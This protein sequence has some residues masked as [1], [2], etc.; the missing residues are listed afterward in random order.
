MFFRKRKNSSR[1]RLHLTL[2]GW[3][4]FGACFLVGVVAVNSGM[5]L[6]IVLLG[7]LL[8]SIHI[9]AVLSRR[10]ISG[11]AVR[12][13]APARCRQ[14]ESVG[15]GYRLTSLRGAGSCL[16]LHV[17]ES[18]TEGLHVPPAACGHLAARGGFLLRSEVL[19]LHRGRMELRGVRL[20]T[21]FPF[22]LLWARRMF[23]QP[24]SLVVWPARGTLAR[25]LLG[26][27][28]AHSSSINPSS[29]SGGADEFVGL[30][31]YR[32]GDSIRWIHLRRSAGRHMPVV[33]EMSKP[34]P[35]TL[36]VILDTLLDASTG[37][38]WAARE[39]AIRLA[40]TLIEDG[41]AAG[42]RV[43][44]AWAQ[45][46]D[47]RV[48]PPAERPGQLNVL[49]D[50]LAEVDENRARTLGETTARLGPRRLCQAD[51]VL[52]SPAEADEAADTLDGESIARLRR[53]SRDLTVLAGLRI[54]DA[55]QDAPLPPEA[56]LPPAPK[57]HAAP[58]GSKARMS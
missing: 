35:R 25:G 38:A 57:V 2:A 8:G 43:G 17:R 14:N 39:R 4:V 37:R 5:A 23:D 1:V 53:E 9:S 41:L 42:F 48:I 15:F 13:E 44:A 18:A 16:A 34:R 7:T 47:V 21:P 51:V 3:A 30:R 11:V 27:G 26:R 36:W 49:L 40:A 55:F 6:L 10:M 50:A 33:R 29:R 32:P 12:R 31:D 19:P 58:A 56:L 52:V 22:G 28:D 45:A 24:D 20:G 54:A 46:D